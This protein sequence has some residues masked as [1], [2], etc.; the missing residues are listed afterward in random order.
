MNRLWDDQVL[1]GPRRSVE[2]DRAREL[3][4]WIESVDVMLDLHSMLWP[5]DPVILCGPADKGRDLALGLGGP[6]LIVSDRGHGNGRRLIDLPRFAEAGTPFTANLIEA[7]EHW[8]PVTVDVAMESVAGMLARTE[9]VVPG[10]DLPKGP[11]K[12]GR[13]ARVTDV[14]TAATSPFAFVQP[15]R[16]CAVL[17]E[18]NTLIAIDGEAEIRT[19][20]DNCLLV[21]PSLRPGRGHTAVRLARF[22][23][24][25]RTSMRGEY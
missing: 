5:S 12:P 21:L 22:D 11:G 16:G 18:R 2:L 19:P 20:Y 23:D 4:P 10:L 9:C 25:H 1:D 15:F 7:G 6:S 8:D 17:P 13:F 24:S 3:R 14:I